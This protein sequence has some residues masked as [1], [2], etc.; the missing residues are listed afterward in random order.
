MNQLFEPAKR[1]SLA[2]KSLTPDTGTRLRHLIK[3]LRNLSKPVTG[4]RS[5]RGGEDEIVP[6]I[7]NRKVYHTCVIGDIAY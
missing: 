4:H 2:D 3:V 5:H 6:S 1:Q 7:E